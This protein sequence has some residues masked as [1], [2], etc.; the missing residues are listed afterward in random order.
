[1]IFFKFFILGT[2]TSLLYPPF[3]MLP[4]GLIIFPYLIILLSKI[5]YQNS[6]LTYF[7]SGFLFGFGFLFIYLL[8]IY[9]PFLVYENTKPYA[10]LALLLPIFLSLFFGLGFLIYKFFNSKILLILITPFIF[11][12]IEFS[13]SNFIYG[14]PWIS[15]SLILSNNFFGFYILKYFGTL[16]SG[17]IIIS[18]FLLASFI[19]FNYKIKNFQKLAFISYSPLI[20][21]LLIPAFSMLNNNNSFSKEITID[22]Q[23]ILSPIKK[24]NKKNIEENIINIINNSNADY[25]VFAE[26]AFPYL[27]DK[28]NSLNLNNFIKNDKK[29][30]FGGT[31][32]EDG[33]YYNSFL[34]LEKDKIHYFDKKILVPFGEFLPLRKYLNFMEIIS[35]NVDFHRGNVARIISTGDKFNIMPIICYEIIFDTIFEN[36]NKK[37]IDIL[38]NITNDSWFGKKIGPYQHFYISRVKSLIANKPLLRVSNNGITAIIDNNGKIIKFSNLN[39]TSNL[40]YKLKIKINNSYLYFHKLFFYYLLFIFILLFIKSKRGV[41]ASE[42]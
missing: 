41:N 26:N 9:N 17:H 13:I 25:I 31:T 4:L 37:K 24:I 21:I 11:I 22:A 5:S 2:L 36:I 33:K 40:I 19:F 3:F 15:N 39:K 38:I 35:G 20:F 1:L 30:I 34:L 16:A 7:F 32:I 18:I 6:F 42:Y 29:V 14:F 8:W 12:L 23:Q 28:N 27:I 10:Y